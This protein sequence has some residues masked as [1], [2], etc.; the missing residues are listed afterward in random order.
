[1]TQKKRILLL[2][3]MT[4][5]Y[6]HEIVEGITRY[7]RQNN[8]WMI[9]LDELGPVTATP[10]WLKKWHCDGVIVRSHN[11]Q[12]HE[13]LKELNIPMVELLGDGKV[14]KSD[15]LSDENLVGKMAF[16]HF[17]EHGFRN[18]GFFSLGQNWFLT[19]FRN[20]FVRE[21]EKS[22]CNCSICPTSFRKIDL[23]ST[24][25]ISDRQMNMFTKW[26]VSLPKPAA[27][28]SPP[29]TNST[30]LLNQCQMQGLNVPDDV[31]IL[32]LG[33]NEVICSITTPSLS[34]IGANGR[35]TGYEAALLLDK[36]MKGETLPQ[37][38]ILIPPEGVVLRQSTDTFA[39]DHADFTAAIQL[40]R[41]RATER[42]QVQEIA[43]ELC[44]SR[45][46]L[47]RWFR[48]YINR[49]PEEEIIRVRM[50]H[51]KRLLRETTL[52]L[53]QIGR[54]S[55]YPLVEHFVRAFRLRMGM[56]PNEFRKNF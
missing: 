34:S 40:I 20:A 9:Y 25:V 43:D 17:W 48:K 54:Q 4:N 10:E 55:G 35:Q 13:Q 52:S 6:T 5:Y 29:V 39:I 7:V 53:E 14:S 26:L 41:Q 42:I 38:P 27:I 50:E 2:L 23:N 47:S 36:K 33:N 1:M 37:L 24:L 51:A 31:A 22:G 56:T 46:T 45:R 16:E 11:L 44:V 21:V 18:F 8:E 12:V 30:V 49:T 3:E 28:F 15:V 32:N 19:E